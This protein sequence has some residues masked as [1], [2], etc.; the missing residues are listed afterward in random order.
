LADTA[1]LWKTAPARMPIPRPQYRL[2]AW[3]QLVTGFKATPQLIRC[4]S[5]ARLPLEWSM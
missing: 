5:R 4:G 1:L 2:F 3:L